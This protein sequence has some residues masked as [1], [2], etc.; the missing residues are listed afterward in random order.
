MFINR[1]N[2]EFQHLCRNAIINP[3]GNQFVY[4]VDNQN[5]ARSPMEM[6]KKIQNYSFMAH[7]KIGKGYSSV[8]YK[9]TNDLNGISYVI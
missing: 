3:S 9:G 4:A 1:E 6:R 7:D 2:Q 8:V 5:K